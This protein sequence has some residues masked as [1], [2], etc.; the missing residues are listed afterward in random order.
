MENI[1]FFEMDKQTY[2]DINVWHGERMSG[3]LSCWMLN[4][5]DKSSLYLLIFSQT[6]IFS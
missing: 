5:T 6:M 4:L 2:A 3:Y 1:S